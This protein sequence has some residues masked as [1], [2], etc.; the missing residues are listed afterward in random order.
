MEK[1]AIY[2]WYG[3]VGAPPENLSI[4][5]LGIVLSCAE[6]FCFLLL[7]LLVVVFFFFLLLCSAFFSLHSQ[8]P[9]ESDDAADL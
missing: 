7:L 2:S 5:L 1:K 9:V 8:Q 3:V 6:L 4:F